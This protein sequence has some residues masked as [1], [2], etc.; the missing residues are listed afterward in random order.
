MSRWKKICLLVTIVFGINWYITYNLRHYVVHYAQNAFNNDID[1]VAYFIIRELKDI[2]L[3][4][5][6]SGEFLYEYSARSDY[7]VIR[8]NDSKTVLALD[9]EG[10]DFDLAD[11]YYNYDKFGNFIDDFYSK[12]DDDLTYEDKIELSKIKEVL[13]QP[14]LDIQPKPVINLQW[15]FNFLNKDMIDEYN[16]RKK[17]ISQ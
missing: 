3:Y 8:R 1:V 14:I 4:Y 2:P 10:Y 16:S 5:R 11:K 15:L 17:N 6:E 9:V 7:P 12:D 13:L